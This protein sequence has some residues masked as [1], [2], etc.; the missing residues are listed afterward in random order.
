[1]QH[2][3]PNTPPAES[4]RV[5]WTQTSVRGRTMSMQLREGTLVSITADVATVRLASGKL[6]D[7]DARLIRDEGQPSDIG[8]VVEALRGR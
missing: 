3:L 2:E 6:V 8:R 7:V 5:S 1:M 4:R